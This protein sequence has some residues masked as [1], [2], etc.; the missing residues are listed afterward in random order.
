[1]CFSSNVYVYCKHYLIRRHLTFNPY[2]H[3]HFSLTNASTMANA[4]RNGFAAPTLLDLKE[5]Y[6]KQILGDNDFMILLNLRASEFNALQKD[7]MNKLI[8]R[9]TCTGYEVLADGDSLVINGKVL[10]EPEDVDLAYFQM[11][12]GAP[13]AKGYIDQVAVHIANLHPTVFV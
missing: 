6:A 8:E 10:T 11:P 2:I 4:K 7:C 12:R 5:Y 1:M 13:L 3:S 9:T